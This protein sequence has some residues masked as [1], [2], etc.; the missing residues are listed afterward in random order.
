MSGGLTQLSAR[1]GMHAYFTKNPE[2]TLFRNKLPPFKNIS[3]KQDINTFITNVDFGAMCEILLT[4]QPYD[5]STMFLQITIPALTQTVGTKSAW[6]KRLGFAMIEKITLTVN[7]VPLVTKSGD[8]MNV[9]FEL[10]RNE[11]HTD[12]VLEMIGDIP[13]LTQYDDTDKEQSIIHVPLSYWFDNSFG[14]H[15]DEIIDSRMVDDQRNIHGFPMNQLH[16]MELG[17]E[18]LFHPISKCVIHN[19]QFVPSLRDLH[20]ISIDLLS[21]SIFHNREE[22]DTITLPY[23]YEHTEVFEILRK[24]MNIRAD[25]I[26]SHHTKAL[27]WRSIMT[28]YKGDT[29]FIYYANNNDWSD[30][31]NQFTDQFLN[32][33]MV[34][35]DAGATPPPFATLNT[36]PSATSTFAGIDIVNN[37]LDKTLWLN[38]SPLIVGDM[39]YMTLISYTI[40]VNVDNTIN[41]TNISN[42]LT[43]E[44]I[45]VPVDEFDVDTRLTNDAD[46]IVRSFNNYGSNLDGSSPIHERWQ[47]KL[48]DCDICDIHDMI[49]A[50]LTIP[51]RHFPCI[52]QEGIY[53]FSFCDEPHDRRSM[54][55]GINFRQ[56]TRASLCHQYTDASINKATTY[57]TAI[58]AHNYELKKD[59]VDI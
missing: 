19:K 28:K 7:D 31:I 41:L 6:I 51:Y 11:S 50:G 2:T 42:D 35:L 25:R 55:V 48:R 43:I 18:I 3:C 27:I 9:L 20:I 37:S 29:T 21:Q 15:D 54:H 47:I 17:I 53:C 39:D 38:T 26:F 5:I 49:Y 14:M 59:D 10:L 23:I 1:N 32:D 8:D 12:T 57:I 44:D 24:K 46:V 22:K 58:T 34:L 13:A 45:S 30:A 40:T 33:S 4:K 36:L 56:H 16:N 52:P